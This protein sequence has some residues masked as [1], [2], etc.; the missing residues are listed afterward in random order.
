MKL[1]FRPAT[2][3]FDQPVPESPQDLRSIDLEMNWETCIKEHNDF[4]DDS[5]DTVNEL[6]PQQKLKNLEKDTEHKN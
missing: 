5:S 1:A 2:H 6:F 3:I 4:E